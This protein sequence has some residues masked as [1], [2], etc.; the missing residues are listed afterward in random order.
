MFSYQKNNRFFAQIADGFTEAAAAELSELGASNI[1]PVYRGLHFSATKKALYR[2]NYQSRLCSRITAPLITFDCHSARYLY[3]TAAQ[4]S[5]RQLLDISNSFAVK[6]T[7]NKSKI[8]HSQ[9]AA[10]RLKDAVVD[11]FKAESGLRPDIDRHNPDLWLDLY[12]NNNRATISMDLSGGSLHRRGYRAD[13][14]EAP[15]QETLAAAIIRLSEWQ[16]ER[17]LIDPMCGSGTLLAEALMHYCRLPAS[18]LRTHFGFEMMPDFQNEIW[19]EVRQEVNNHITPLPTGLIGGSDIF[20]PAS[21]VAR[22]NL[23]NLPEGDKVIIKTMPF[24]NIETLTNTTIIC[25]PPYGVRLK[26]ST[27]AAA[28]IEEFGNFL[29]RKCTGSTAYIYLGRRELLKSVGLHPSWKKPL[30]AGGL[31]GV[32]A[33]Y[34]LY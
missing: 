23:A 28:L 8:N 33:K 24:Q 2:I 26:S 18:L 14:V 12:I 21:D 34:E 29:K 13:A 4:I 25:N 5:W 17:P 22:A 11:Y 31:D 3:K 10:L 20:K 7:V 1:D 27:E 9:F 16:G 32:L 19:Q 6:A 30:K 15:M